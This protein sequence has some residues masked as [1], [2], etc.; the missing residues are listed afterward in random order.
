MSLVKIN[1]DTENDIESL[2]GVGKVLAKRI[3]EYRNAKGFFKNPEDLAR[4]DGVSDDL[5]RVLAVQID[6]TVPEPSTLK[7]D[8][9]KLATPKMLIFMGCFGIVAIIWKTIQD[10]NYYGQDIFKTTSGLV[11]I[12]NTSS[13]LLFNVSLISGS[14]IWLNSLR[15]SNIQHLANYRKTLI[16]FLILLLMSILALGMG[17]AYYYQYFVGWNRL[18]ENGA[19]LGGLLQFIFFSLVLGPLVL[20]WSKPSLSTNIILTHSPEICL[21]VYGIVYSSLIVFIKP[22]PFWV[23]LTVLIEGIALIY[24]GVNN[25][26]SGKTVLSSILEVIIDSEWRYNQVKAQ[27]WLTWINVRL[28]N[29]DQQKEL[30][31]ALDQVY[32]PSK[33]RSFLGTMFISVGGW[34][35]ISVLSSILDWF[36]QN[37]LDKFIKIFN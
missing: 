1:F 13:L 20:I 15:S 6:W 31:D 36:V 30:R 5:A 23:G 28:P 18:F 3:V 24:I 9:D 19:A 7:V 35:I 26:R 25:F 34:L 11:Y 10:Y 21:I 17:N 22:I 14:Y 4:V 2:Y 8:N 33:W 12:W 37:W 32:P 16:I 29:V 27:A